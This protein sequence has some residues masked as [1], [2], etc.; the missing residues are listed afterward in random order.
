[1]GN[2]TN[3]TN[4]VRG[5]KFFKK[6]LSGKVIDIGGGQDPVIPTAKVFDLKDGDAQYISKYEAQENYDCVHSSHC[7]EH[8]MDV[9]SALSQW[10]SLVKIGGHMV[11]TVPHEDLYEQKIWPSIFNDDHKA[12]FR[13]NQVNSW[14][15]VSYDMKALCESLKN[16]III[17]GCIQDNGY[18]YNL[19]YKKISS[20]FKRIYRWHFSKN[21]VKRIFGRFIYQLLYNRYYLNG[22]YNS[23]SPIDQTG[24]GALAQI[25]VILKKT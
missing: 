2:E 25:Q 7:L 18:D 24:G 16:A 22:Y 17:D 5:G 12:T 6:Y 1:M 4:K 15:N 13:L 10:W 11:I 9:P 19:Q 23:G 21:K 8:M 20:K 14:S 3:K